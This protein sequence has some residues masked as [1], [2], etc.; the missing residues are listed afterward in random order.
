MH[1]EP[2]TSLRLAD[3]ALSLTEHIF[4]HCEGSNF[5]KHGHALILI[6]TVVWMAMDTDSGTNVIKTGLV[7][8]AF[9]TI[10]LYELVVLACVKPVSCQGTCKAFIIAIIEHGRG[11]EDVCVFG[12]TIEFKVYFVFIKDGTSWH[13]CHIN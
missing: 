5:C 7:K 4:V 1:V 3:E 10:N 9:D 13:H 2:P 6:N 11:N 8:A 12:A